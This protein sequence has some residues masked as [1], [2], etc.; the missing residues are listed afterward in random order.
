MLENNKMLISDVI[1]WFYIPPLVS[2]W[3][4]VVSW[5][6]EVGNYKPAR[7]LIKVQTTEKVKREKILKLDLTF[8]I[9][10]M[11]ENLQIEQFLWRRISWLSDNNLT[12]DAM[13]FIIL[14]SIKESCNHSME[15]LSIKQLVEIKNIFN[16]NPHT[17]EINRVGSSNK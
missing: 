8:C 11:T 5:W 12:L 7:C 15:L 16:P 14:M 10:F 13:S 4:F 6:S 2:L 17:K 1:L 3:S 9:I